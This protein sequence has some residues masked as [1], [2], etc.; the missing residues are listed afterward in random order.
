MEVQKELLSLPMG[1][2]VPPYPCPWKE[3]SQE[4]KCLLDR[5]QFPQW[6]SWGPH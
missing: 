1:T 6:G 2:T 3:L 4:Q 5:P